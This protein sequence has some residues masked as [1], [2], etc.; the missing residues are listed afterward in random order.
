MLFNS[1]LQL[2]KRQ[3]EIKFYEYEVSYIKDSISNLLY[4]PSPLTKLIPNAL[5]LSTQNRLHITQRHVNCLF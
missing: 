4:L 5:L 1:H 3:N 2:D